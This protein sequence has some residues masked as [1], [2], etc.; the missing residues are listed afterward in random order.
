ML[1]GRGHTQSYPE[2]AEVGIFFGGKHPV[3]WSELGVYLGFFPSKST[4]FFSWTW[5]EALIR[6]V[7]PK[8]I[9]FCVFSSPNSDF[10]LTKLRLFL[11]K[12][13]LFLTKLRLFLAKLRPPLFQVC[14]YLFFW[15]KMGN[16][17]PLLLIFFCLK[18]QKQ[19]PPK[20]PPKKSQ[21]PP[22]SPRQF[23]FR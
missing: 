10:S 14:S 1:L 18:T 19:I 4:V 9:M 5:M 16:F 21:I 23:G 20:S 6:S 15:W 8:R 7:V 2:E 17:I 22:K 13:R 11:T 12:L 3:I